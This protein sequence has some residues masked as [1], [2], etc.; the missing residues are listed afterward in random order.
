MY[1]LMY[2]EFSVVF[3]NERVSEQDVHVYQYTI[4]IVYTHIGNKDNGFIC[5]HLR[6]QSTELRFFDTV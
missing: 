6:M 5:S 4:F 1:E 3:G 2:G